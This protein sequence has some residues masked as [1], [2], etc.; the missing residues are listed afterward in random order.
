MCASLR[1]V[2]VCFSP[3]GGVCY[4]AGAVEVCA[5]LRGV[6]MCYW[7]GAAPR[8]WMTQLQ[9]VPQCDQINMGR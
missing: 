5:S 1:G 6:G 3:R 4:W 7:V 9:P 2:G 8:C